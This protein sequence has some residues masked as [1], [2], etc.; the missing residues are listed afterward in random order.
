VSRRNYSIYGGS[1]VY[2]TFDAQGNVVQR[3]DGY[4]NV[5]TSRMY[6]AHGTMVGKAVADPFGYGGQWGYYTDTETGLQLLTFRY[7]D[8]NVG[9]FLTR[10]P[11]GYEGG[12][13]LY[14]YVE[15]NVVN[16]FD[17]L[18]WDGLKLPSNPS[19]LP[20]SW[21]LD[22]SHR[23]PNGQRFRHPNGDFLDFHRKNP[24][25]SSKSHGGNDHWHHNGGDEHLYP[26]DEVPDPDAPCQPKQPPPPVPF[27]PLPVPRPPLP[28]RP[29]PWWNRIPLP[30]FP[31]LPIMINPC[32]VDPSF[33]GCRRPGSMAQNVPSDTKGTGLTESASRGKRPAVTLPGVKGGRKTS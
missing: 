27:T 8:P 29:L 18:G 17:P 14:G 20:S 3:F 13:N 23:Y 33:P 21:R 31:V 25:K 2:Y 5:L 22:P 24:N 9:R 6:T 26:G 7:Y 11:I 15:N 28:S 4:G 1:S 19:G 30:T 16:N 32:L 10:D 12:I